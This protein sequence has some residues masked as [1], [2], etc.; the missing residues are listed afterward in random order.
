MSDQPQHTAP[1]QPLPPQTVVNVHMTN[2]NQA[3][4][5]ATA[6]ATAAAP[7]EPRRRKSI[8]AAYSFLAVG[9]WG[10]FHRIY[11][12]RPFGGWL[13]LFWGGWLLSSAI[14]FALLPSLTIP[15]AFLLLECIRI[16]RWVRHHNA[17]VEGTRRAPDAVQALPAAP[18]HAAAAPEVEL[19]SAAA[20]AAPPDLR[21][22]LLRTAHQ[23]D[24]KLT[25]TQAVMETGK[26]FQEVEDCFRDMVQ[27]GYVDVDNEPH[28]GVIVYVFPELVG[29]PRTAGPAAE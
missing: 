11:L 22:L 21:T 16:P 13:V 14:P 28:S 1:Q 18:R 4:A 23:A 7:A 10:G 3:T 20:T 27:A 26:T 6:V 12:N 15:I 29:R 19:A 9:G 5:E 2:T 17:L 8:V 24:G 25:V